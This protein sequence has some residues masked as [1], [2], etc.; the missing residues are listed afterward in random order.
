MLF[1]GFIP[2]RE[3]IRLEIFDGQRISAI[4]QNPNLPPIWVISDFLIDE[5][6]DQEAP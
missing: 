6:R 1:D 4:I 3:L 5:K 2:I